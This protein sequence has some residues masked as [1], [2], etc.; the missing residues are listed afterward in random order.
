MTENLNNYKQ[1]LF[2]ILPGSAEHHDPPY[3][4]DSK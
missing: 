3:I 2:T 1:I 4:G